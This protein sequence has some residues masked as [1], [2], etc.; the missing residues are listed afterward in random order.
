MFSLPLVFETCPRVLKLPLP[1]ENLEKCPPLDFLL[2]AFDL[3]FSPSVCTFLFRSLPCAVRVLSVVVFVSGSEDPD[4]L[5]ESES[6][7][8]SDCQVAVFKAVGTWAVCPLFNTCRDC[9]GADTGLSVKFLRVKIL[10]RGLDVA[11]GCEGSKGILPMAPE[12]APPSGEGVRA[13]KEAFVVGSRA[14]SLNDFVRLGRGAK[15]MAL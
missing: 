8:E 14:D 2:C 15:S 1:T 11:A 12:E 13:V 6:E 4:E 5:S 10:G 7:L 9:R 3:S